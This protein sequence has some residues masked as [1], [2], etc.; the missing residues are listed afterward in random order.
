MV[1]WNG[2]VWD[3]YFKIWCV[4]VYSYVFVLFGNRVVFGFCFVLFLVGVVEIVRLG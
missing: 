4:F 1:N 3:R 2:I